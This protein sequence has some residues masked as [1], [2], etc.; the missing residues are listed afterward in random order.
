MIKDEMVE[1][2]KGGSYT[3]Q[4]LCD[5]LNIDDDLRVASIIAKLQ[6]EK[7]IKRYSRKTI[8]REDGGAII[9]GQYKAI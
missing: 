9:L 1:I 3:I 4:E 6:I 8:Y 7:K 2:L 5:R